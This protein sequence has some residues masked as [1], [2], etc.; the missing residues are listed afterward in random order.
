MCELGICLQDGLQDKRGRAI[1]RRNP[2]AGFRLFLH[3]AEAGDRSGAYLLGHAYDV[4]LG[5]TP[6]KELALRWYHQAARNGDSCASSNMA[7]I[8]RDDR[9]FPT[10]FRWWQRSVAMR[11]GD[12]AVDV[13]YCYQYGIGTRRNHLMARRMYRRAIS[14]KYITEWGREEAMYHLAVAAIDDRDVRR[15]IPLLARAAADGDYPEATSL[16]NEI[17]SK[18]DVH[19]CRCRRFLYKHLPGHAKCPQHSPRVRLSTAVQDHA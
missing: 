9:K 19:P 15:A 13:G 1:M 12:A 7:V 10:A 18:G 6:N 17:R 8:Y 16:L 5:T 14:S 4:G 11:D 2:T 3:A